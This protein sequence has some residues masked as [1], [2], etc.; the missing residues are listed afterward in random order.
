MKFPDLIEPITRVGREIRMLDDFYLEGD[1]TSHERVLRDGKLDWDL[2]VVAGPRG[3]LLF[4]LDLDYQP[5]P[6]EI[7]FRFG[8]PREATFR[9]RVPTYVSKP[10]EVFR[11][12][13]DGVTAVKHQPS[14]GMLQIQ[15]RVS[16][17]A[18]YLAAINAGERERIETR[19]Q[20]LLLE[21][22]SCGMDPGGK[23]SDL[24]LLQQ[25]LESGRQ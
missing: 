3:A 6:T 13:A 14:A 25:L 21:E 16:R 7:V 4:A 20:A 22:N 15:D 23:P 17:T 8:P 18:V 19:R 11:V 1:A 24:Q 2:D 5:D 9:F 12:D 10:A